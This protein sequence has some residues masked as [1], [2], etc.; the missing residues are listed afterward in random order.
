[1]PKKAE[2]LQKEREFLLFIISEQAMVIQ[3]EDHQ[4]I[5]SHLHTQVTSNYVI[6]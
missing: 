1:M 6:K 2:V 3:Q 4:H 5:P